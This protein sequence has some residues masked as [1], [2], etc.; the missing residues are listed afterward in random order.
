MLQP[1]RMVEPQ[2]GRGQESFFCGPPGKLQ[3]GQFLALMVIPIPPTKTGGP[4][5]TNLGRQKAKEASWPQP[6]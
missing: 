3:P 6:K 4:R 1:R 2:E 5:R